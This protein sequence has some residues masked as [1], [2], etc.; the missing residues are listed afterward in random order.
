MLLAQYF[1]KQRTSTHILSTYICY[2]TVP[3]CKLKCEIAPCSW[4]FKP[5]VLLP[6]GTCNLVFTSVVDLSMREQ[7]SSVHYILNKSSGGSGSERTVASPFSGRRRDGWTPRA[8]FYK[9]F[10]FNV[11]FLIFFILPLKS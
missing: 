9:Y 5:C 10:L 2:S 7:Q 6:T 11:Y 4:T 8:D 1:L 3:T